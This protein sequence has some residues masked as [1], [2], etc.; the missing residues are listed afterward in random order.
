M[1]QK[2]LFVIAGWSAVVSVLCS[3]GMY[4]L[5]GSGRG[6]LFQLVSMGTYITSAIVFLALYLF[7]KHQSG[8]LS[9]AMMLAGIVGMV[10]EGIGTGPETPLAVVANS[11]YGLSFVLLGYLGFG[12]PQMPRWVAGCAYAVAVSSL[13]T[14][15]LTAVGQSTLSE[16][17]G[18]VFLVAWIAWSAGILY[19]LSLAKMA[20][21]AS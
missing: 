6:P 13:A 18:L 20:P 10:L 2:N 16:I 14:A 17:A 9:L 21:V 7:H 19:R 15:F 3:F 11:L 12:S 8:I 1:S 5:V 4:G